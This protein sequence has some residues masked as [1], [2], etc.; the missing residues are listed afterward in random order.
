MNLTDLSEIRVYKGAINGL[1]RDKHGR[2]PT[3]LL[4]RFVVGGRAP[5]GRCCPICV[6]P[7][8]GVGRHRGRQIAA[9]T[10]N[11]VNRMIMP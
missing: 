10:I 4:G 2:A 5:V 6:R 9:P 8:F 11:V 7:F 3:E 1:R